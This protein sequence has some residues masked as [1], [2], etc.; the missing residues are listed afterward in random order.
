[1]CWQEAVQREMRLGL[2]T[3]SW[4]AKAMHEAGRDREARAYFEDQLNRL[5]QS[6][7]GLNAA[8]VRSL[9]QL[10]ERLSRERAQG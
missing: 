3:Y 6:A 10:L 8:D 7:G 4:I 5:I 1:M 9:Q 2:L